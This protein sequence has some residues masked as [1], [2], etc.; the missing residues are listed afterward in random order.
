MGGK[1]VD[2]REREG[3][4]G[5]NDE[6]GKGANQLANQ[7]SVAHIQAKTIISRSNSTNK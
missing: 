5:T 6:T 2:E 4:G 3:T 1:R 7:V